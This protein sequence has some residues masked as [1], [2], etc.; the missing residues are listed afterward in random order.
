MLTNLNKLFVESDY[1]GKRIV[2][3]SLFNER[4]IFGNKGCRT[5]KVNEVIEVLTKQGVAS[6]VLKK[7][8]A[9]KIDS[10]S[11]KVHTK[12]TNSN[13]LNKFLAKIDGLKYLEF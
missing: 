7:R 9:I 4:I 8:K 10:F 12:V 1:T 3:G 5:T 6:G 13:Q 2:V 11:A